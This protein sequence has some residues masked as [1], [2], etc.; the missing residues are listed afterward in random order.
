[1]RRLGLVL[2]IA[3]LATAASAQNADLTVINGLPGLG[4][5][6]DLAVDGS[7]TLT[8]I[9]Y[10]QSQATTLAAGTH[11]IEI[12]DGGAVVVSDNLTVAAGDN[13]TAVAHLLD[14]GS[15][16]LSFFTNDLSAVTHYGDGRVVLRH[17]ADIGTFSARLQASTFNWGPHHAGNSQMSNGDEVSLDRIAD[18]YDLTLSTLSAPPTF[19]GFGGPG[20]GGPGGHHHFGFGGGF[21]M[22]VVVLGPETHVVTADTATIIH[23]VGIENDASFMTVVQTVALSPA[24]APAAAD[25]SVTGS[26]VGGSWAAG[27]DITYGLTGAGANAL[28]MVFVSQ[29]NT[30]QTGIGGWNIGLGI[31]GNGWVFPVAIGHADATGVY[32]KT[33]T[34]PAGMTAFAP[35]TAVTLYHQAIS[36]SSGHWW[37]SGLFNLSDIESVVINP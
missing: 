15:Q 32:A 21:G 30:P 9:A 23:V 33:Y 18:S 27:G 24:T 28:V 1:M 2:L 13:V 35:T 5:A 29:D 11:L 8:G 14:D 19:P 34:V 31:G 3:I 10:G 26:L 12:L 25:L 20:F 4:A 16:A 37:G 17:L 6:A 22:P 36:F 7:T